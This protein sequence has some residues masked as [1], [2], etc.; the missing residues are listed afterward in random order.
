MRRHPGYSC[1][2]SRVTGKNKRG[3]PDFALGGSRLSAWLLAVP[4][5]IGL[6][7]FSLYPFIQLVG[8]SLSRSSLGRLYREWPIISNYEAVLTDQSFYDALLRTAIFAIPVSIIEVALGLSIALLLHSNLRRA[9]W[10]RSVILLPLMTPPMMVAVAWKLILAPSG[11]LLNGFLLGIGVID[12][13]ISF[14]G[15]MPAAFI[16]VAFADTWQ[17]T[18]FVAILAY[19]AIQVLPEE[20][21]EAARVDGASSWTTFWHITLPMLAPALLA[22]LLLRVV[23]ALKLFDLVY[24]L[25]FG[26]PGF[27]TT[28]AGFRIWQT[29]L[30]QFD[31][32]AAAA[33][34]MVFIVAVTLLTLPLT[35]IHRRSEAIAG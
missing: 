28:V 24:G 31:I 9:R 34:T 17:W 7:V 21:F 20:I 22:I 29:A 33:Q 4:L 13:P 15:T 16:S 5:L 35:W 6:G 32:G 3:S 14:L 12:Q 18:P 10:V 30:Q 26:G 8:L 2:T 11:G 25:T 19:A 23:M 1:L 27:G